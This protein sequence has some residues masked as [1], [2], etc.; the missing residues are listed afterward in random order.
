[1]NPN[2]LKRVAIVLL[3]ASSS[4]YA[5]RDKGSI[6]DKR[7]RG[8]IAQFKG[9]VSLFAKNLDTGAVYTLSLIH[10]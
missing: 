8:E 2:V 3:L 6:L 4:A 7:V 10:I 9:R 1:M 5:Q